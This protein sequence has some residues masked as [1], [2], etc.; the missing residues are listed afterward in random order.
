MK[1]TKYE[2]KKALKISKII[3]R[4]IDL[5]NEINLRT[6]DIFPDLVR[7][8]LFE[9]D[10]NNG[11]HFRRFLKKISRYGELK[12]LIPQC[13]QVPPLKDEIFNEWYFNDA[14][15]NMPSVKS[16]E[17]DIKVNTAEIEPEL[18]K[19]LIQ[20]S[21]KMDINEAFEIVQMLISGINPITERPQ[22]DLGVCADITVVEALKTII[23]PESHKIEINN[24]KD[25]LVETKNDLEDRDE[26][27]VME[28]HLSATALGNLK[29]LICSQVID[30]MIREAY[31]IGYSEI[32]YKGL[33]RGLK[34]KKNEK[35]S[36][37]IVYPESLA[38]ML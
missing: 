36:K 3:Q 2:V 6:T 34:F 13:S 7:K 5:T 32:T 24:T 38:E 16:L 9:P 30:Y 8:G 23:A 26:V 21:V 17:R 27:D 19:T 1:L 11:I 35:G 18:L 31:I 10:K 29:G 14:K 4:R 15:D 22:D 20:P 12:T 28:R 33:D 25:E 37:W